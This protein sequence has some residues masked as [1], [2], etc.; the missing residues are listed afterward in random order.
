MIEK[1]IVLM[2]FITYVNLLEVIKNDILCI[3]FSTPDYQMFLFDS[4][5]SFIVGLLD[6]AL[7]YF[8]TSKQLEHEFVLLP[9]VRGITF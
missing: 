4:I 1:Y 8:H 9:L 5:S 6:A 7:H 3:L 2:I